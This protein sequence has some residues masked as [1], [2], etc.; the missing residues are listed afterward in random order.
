MRYAGVLLSVL[1]Y[2]FLIPSLSYASSIYHSFDEIPLGGI[3]PPKQYSRALLQRV[4]GFREYLLSTETK[5]FQVCLTDTH[6]ADSK[7]NP[8][9]TLE[10]TAG[11]T[12]QNFHIRI[13]SYK[14][15]PNAICPQPRSI[16]DDLRAIWYG[17]IKDMLSFCI[18][19][20]ANSITA[21][22]SQDEQENITALRKC[23]G[24]TPGPDGEPREI[25]SVNFILGHDHFEKIMS[26]QQIKKFLKNAPMR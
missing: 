7:I 10:V 1:L 4:T 16:N 21:S 15:L 22:V 13:N 14:K 20:G 3:I 17:A 26:H 6:V 12:Y 5:V 24:F 8:L 11:N 9:G 19:N 18:E 25:N 2:P 23:F